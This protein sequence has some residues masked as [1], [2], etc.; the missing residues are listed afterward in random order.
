[1]PVRPYLSCL[2]CPP[3]KDDGQPLVRWLEAELKSKYGIRKDIGRRWL[4]DR[5]LLPLLDGLDELEPTRQEQCVQ[6]INQ[7]QKDSDYRPDHLV[8][9]CR[10]A[11]YQNCNTKL[12]LHGA[13]Y[14]QPLTAEQVCNYLAR[15]KHPDLWNHVQTDAGLLELARSPLLLRM[16][17]LSYETRLIQEWQNFRL[18]KERHQHLFDEYIERMLSREIKRQEYTKERTLHWLTWLAQRLKE[19]AHCD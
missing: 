3:G 7:F 18:T 9:C 4:Q 12:H 16:L 15:I 11:E 6:A 13:I 2:T 14:L 5:R 10:L 1:M 19:Q 8:V 17:T